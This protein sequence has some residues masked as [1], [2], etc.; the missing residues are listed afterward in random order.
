M[1]PKNK[2]L[3]RKILSTLTALSLS[4]AVFAVPCAPSLTVNAG[5]ITNIVTGRWAAIGLEYFERG[6][7]RALGSAAAHAENETVATILSK[8]KRLLGNPQSNALGD[9]K[10]LC[11]EMNQKLTYLTSVVQNNNTYVSKELQ[12]I[13]QKISRTNYNNCIN[14]L[15]EIN[16]DSGFVIGKFNALI[17]AVNQYD[18]N[19]ADSIR[20]LRLAYDDLYSI[21]E[22]TTAGYM[23]KTFSFTDDAEK[24]ASLLS[25]YDYSNGMNGTAPY[26]SYDPGD[27]S[28]WGDI[29]GGNT[30]IENYYDLLSTSC[31]FDHEM[32]QNMTAE[33]N[34]LAG[35][36][37]QFIEAYTMYI[38][39]Y[40][41]MAYAESYDD[42]VDERNKQ[43]SVDLAWQ[44]YDRCC[45]MLLRALAQM[46]D[47]HADRMN[48]AMRS[49]DVETTIYFNNI[50]D[51]INAISVENDRTNHTNRRFDH[52]Y[53][54]NRNRTAKTMQAYM[55]R[56]YN[57]DTAYIIRKTNDTQPTVLMQ[58]LEYLAAEENMWDFTG[59][60]CDYYNLAFTAPTSPVG[61]NIMNKGS[62]VLP[63]ISTG[64]YEMAGRDIRTYLNSHGITEIPNIGSKNP[65]ILTDVYSWDPSIGF[66]GNFDVHMKFIQLPDYM[67]SDTAPGMKNFDMDDDQKYFKD[68]ETNIIYTGQPVIAYTLPNNAGASYQYSADSGA[69]VHGG[70]NVLTSG[71][72]VTLRIKPDD[73]KYIKSLQLFDRHAKDEKKSEYVLCTYIDESDELYRSDCG[74]YPEADGYYRFIL[75]VPFRDAD[76]SLTLGDSPVKS[77]TVSLEQ[78]EILPEYASAKIYYDRDGGILLFDNF[79]NDSQHTYNTGDTVKVA[80]SPYKGYTCTG[81]SVMDANGNEYPAEE[82]ITDDYLRLNDFQSNYSFT[83]P[84]TDVTVKAVY[85][86]T[87]YVTLEKGRHVRLGFLNENGSVND[88]SSVLS[89]FPAS[90]VTIQASAESGYQL[91]RIEVINEDTGKDVP[92][93]FS[94]GFIRFTMPQNNV[95]VL[96]EAEWLDDSK[97]L[98]AVEA[99]SRALL[100]LTDSTGRPLNVDTVQAEK[101][102]TVFFKVLSDMP[103]AA[104]Q[105]YDTAHQAVAV[106][107]SEKGIYRIVMPDSDVTIG[108]AYADIAI[109]TETFRSGVRFADAGGTVSDTETLTVF[110][111]STVYLKDTFPYPH[112]LRV[113][114]TGGSE[115]PLTR[116]ADTLYSFTAPDGAVT[117][118]IE[119]NVYTIE[120][121]A[122]AQAYA[123]LLWCED[124]PSDQKTVLNAYEGQKVYLQSDPQIAADYRKMEI[125]DA[126]GQPVALTPEGTNLYSFKAYAN[127]VISVPPFQYHTMA[128]GSVANGTGT[129]V[130]EDTVTQ[131]EG[132][133]GEWQDISLYAPAGYSFSSCSAV[134]TDDGSDIPVNYTL[135]S[136]TETTQGVLSVVR[137]QM[138]ESDITLHFV[139]EKKPVVYIDRNGFV[140]DDSQKATAYIEVKDNSVN[141]P[142]YTA[143]SVACPLDCHTVEGRFIYDE[144]NYPTH[145]QI[146]G[147]TTGTVFADTDVSA[148]TVEF[149]YSTA[150]GTAFG[151]DILVVPTFAAFIPQADVV[152]SNYAELVAFAENVI[153]DYEHYEK[154]HAV[155]SNNIIVTSDD[156]VWTQGIGS[157][158]EN[159]PFR[160]TFDGQGFGI[161]SLKIKNTDNGALFEYIGAEG[162]VK[163]L[164]VIDCDFTV[165]SACAGG[166]AAVNEGMID[167]CIV[168]INT[169]SQKTIR[170]HNGQERILS[171][172]NSAVNGIVS[173]GIAGHN[174][175]T[176][177]GCRS[178]AYVIGKDC[179][180]IAGINDGK[181]YGCANNGPV[182][183]DSIVN[184]RCA[185]IAVVNNGTIESSYNSGKL[186]GTTQTVFAS[187]AVENNSDEI[188]HV[189]YHQTENLTPFDDDS[190]D[191]QPTEACKAL[192]IEYMITK[193]FADELNAVTDDSVQWKHIAYNGVKTNQGL[194]IVK[195]RFIENVTVVNDAKM[196]IK[197]AILKA[198]KIN[199]KPMMLRSASYN[200]MLPAAGNRTMTCAYDMTAADQNGNE[201]PAEVWCEGVTV[202]VPVTANDAQIMIL[203]DQNE[204]I[205]VTPDS[206]ENGWATFTLT[207]PASFA[208]AENISFDEP[209]PT[210][211][212]IKPDDGNVKTGESSMPLTAACAVLLVSVLAVLM[213]RRKKNRE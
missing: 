49:Y 170:L 5:T 97:H 100:T 20:A 164:S 65:Y 110:C 173:G 51:S 196:K 185:G 67:T 154:A 56:P 35:I 181:I 120:A 187:V 156:A 203:N 28:H 191:Y 169:E 178:S 127:T 123:V 175:G 70:Y 22:R 30:V 163:D 87:N 189:F 161:V 108:V 12:K 64:A 21:Y 206:I 91:S 109:D 139:M 78:S 115:I 103:D 90:A 13:D 26:Y 140:Y 42:M 1:K 107:P 37:S 210:P 3:G 16:G 195:G 130:Q 98:A 83:M 84:D 44:E 54:S 76:I 60:T 155:L 192:T 204:A 8:T 32:V 209:T 142:V 160:G 81:I 53:V 68:K 66:S 38:S 183:K 125:K 152:I 149:S 104:L 188:I 41:Q 135:S 63:L 213:T 59:Y 25:S 74:I 36:T 131:Q 61:I 199:Y 201:L 95:T 96:A 146:I 129:F 113:T 171:E 153:N 211:T 184:K 176:V 27:K 158:S 94:D 137:C 45:Y 18:A 167:H 202:S 177:K 118:R 73:G 144:N 194:P 101:G 71:D 9:I 182:G 50:R 172:F 29:K 79:S 34:Y 168:G 24:L 124:N 122:S 86:K 112:T 143:D 212:P 119:A 162:V 111:G 128:I 46:I 102:E 106:Q 7:M 126:N 6:V 147:Q 10:A 141:P 197:A 134:H 166:I 190:S 39:Y 75:N 150:D 133:A 11:M 205:V 179:G 174:K 180:G 165:M 121:D 138:P 198:M 69:S 14:N 114:G 132:I 57:A 208:V 31:A 80:V 23:G 116:S 52:E 62:Q 105:V 47:L 2:R 145:I 58:E 136:E 48:G 151:E 99:E 200:T 17:Y 19:N 159:K 4:A 207:E 157:V 15:E 186:T 77:H 33:Y 88:T 55:V 85:S 40:A 117:V 193:A 92:C 72:V 93:T 43:S 89:Y 148:D 82:V